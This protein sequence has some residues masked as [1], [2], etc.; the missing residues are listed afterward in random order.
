MHDANLIPPFGLSA[1]RIAARVRGALWWRH[2][3]TDQFGVTAT[4]PGD[5]DERLYPS[6][7]CLPIPFA[8]TP[9]WTLGPA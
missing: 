6:Q 3:V 1:L 2:N 9:A 8:F 4:P 5:F 7:L